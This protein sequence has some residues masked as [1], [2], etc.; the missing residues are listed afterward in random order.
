MFIKGA[1]SSFVY[2][3]PTDIAVVLDLHW[4]LVAWMQHHT[5]TNVW[6][7]VIIV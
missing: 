7:K 1:L 2:V 5:N 3:K 4:H 6:T